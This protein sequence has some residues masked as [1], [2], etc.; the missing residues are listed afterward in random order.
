[1]QRPSPINT[2]QKQRDGPTLYSFQQSWEPAVFTAYVQR[3]NLKF[4]EVLSLVQGRTASEEMQPCI[5]S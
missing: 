1:M 3:K 2:V 5:Q 4:S